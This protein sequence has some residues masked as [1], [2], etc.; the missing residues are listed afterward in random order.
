MFHGQQQTKASQCR[1][2]RPQQAEALAAP[3]TVAPRRGH[4][5]GRG[6]TGDQM[7]ALSEPPTEI[8]VAELLNALKIKPEMHTILR[9]LLF[10][11]DNLIKALKES[12]Q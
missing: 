10:Q 3:A 8:E 12:K 11:R 2:Q 6:T 1:L 7:K 5:D 4:R 9:R